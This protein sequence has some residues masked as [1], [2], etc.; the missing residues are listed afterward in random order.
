MEFVGLSDRFPSVLLDG[1]SNIFEISKRS[2]DSVFTK[3]RIGG[4]F[5]G[6]HP[7]SFYKNK[8]KIKRQVYI[9]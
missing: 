9:F 7:T 3:W 6:R 5:V 4:E 8:N 2:F 1:E